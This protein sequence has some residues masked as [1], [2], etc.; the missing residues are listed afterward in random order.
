MSFCC[1]E[2]N[3]C[4]NA[5]TCLSLEGMWVETLLPGWLWG[6]CGADDCR[7]K[8]GNNDVTLIKTGALRWHKGLE[9]TKLL[10]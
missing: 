10:A 6:L 7:W 5:L 4:Q 8:E 9:I 3:S 1:I 2:A